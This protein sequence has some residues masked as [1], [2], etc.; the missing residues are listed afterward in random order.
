MVRND[1]GMAIALEPSIYLLLFFFALLGPCSTSHGHQ[2]ATNIVYRLLSAIAVIGP[3]IFISSFSLSGVKRRDG[4]NLPRFYQVPI[5]E[6]ILLNI[7]NE[8]RRRKNQS[9][10]QVWQRGN[11]KSFTI[12]AS[13][14]KTD[15]NGQKR[16]HFEWRRRSYCSCCAV[17]RTGVARMAGASIEP[18]EI[19]SFRIHLPQI[20]Q[21]SKRIVSSAYAPTQ[22]ALSSIFDLICTQ[23]E[24]TKW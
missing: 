10:K 17:T 20:K 3:T 22:S 5:L 7:G 21:S 1:S 16:W 13:D 23:N 4:V 15:S 8:R 11:G 19:I 24:F 2:I 14:T 9:R 18:T 12:S 6:T